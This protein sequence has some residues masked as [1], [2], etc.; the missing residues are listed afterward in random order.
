MTGINQLQDRNEELEVAALA[1]RDAEVLS[2]HKELKAVREEA[3]EKTKAV[4]AAWDQKYSE[5]VGQLKQRL[6]FLRSEKARLRVEVKEHKLAATIEK[7]KD[8]AEAEL[9]PTSPRGENQKREEACERHIG[10][11]RLL[12]LGDKLEKAMAKSQH[13]RTSKLQDTTNRRATRLVPLQFPCDESPTPAPTKPMRKTSLLYP[14]SSYVPVP[15]VQGTPYDPVPPMRS[16]NLVDVSEGE[17]LFGSMG[18][19]ANPINKSLAEPRASR[20]GG[21]GQNRAP[22]VANRRRL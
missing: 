15:G 3:A 11:R 9:A 17:I 20:T 13:T 1:Q 19:T 2:A 7:Q 18:L 6:T 5:A 10:A 14:A 8:T 22:R 4:E 12:S 16:S 21:A